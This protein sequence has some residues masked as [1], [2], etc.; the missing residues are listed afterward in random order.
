[1]LSEHSLVLGSGA[2]HIA[3]LTTSST[4]LFIIME[5]HY[6]PPSLGLRPLGFFHETSKA[7]AGIRGT[8]NFVRTVRAPSLRCCQ[9]IHQETLFP[10]PLMCLPQTLTLPALSFSSENFVLPCFTAIMTH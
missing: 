5:S 9:L 7:V 3:L 10:P 8:W 1:M 6:C 2:Q 4:P